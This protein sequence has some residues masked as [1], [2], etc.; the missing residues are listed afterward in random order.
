MIESKLH[1]NY[2]DI[3]NIP[4]EEVDNRKINKIEQI[5]KVLDDVYW[6]DKKIFELAIQRFNLIPQQTIFIDDR[7]EN[8]TIIFNQFLIRLTCFENTLELACFTNFMITSSPVF[9]LAL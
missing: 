8:N 5:D 7:L 4:N 9:N 6:Y 2:K 3:S 1:F